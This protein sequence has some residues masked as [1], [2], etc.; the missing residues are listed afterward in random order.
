MTES[1]PGEAPV[2]LE[3][4]AS[5][6]FFELREYDDLRHL[7]FGRDTQMLAFQGEHWTVPNP[8]PAHPP[9]PRLACPSP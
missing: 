4:A 6:E 1:L 9:A 7:I 5:G 3:A 8:E 2:Y